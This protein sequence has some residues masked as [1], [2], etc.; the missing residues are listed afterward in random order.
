ML[1]IIKAGNRIFFEIEI[2]GDKSWIIA[3]EYRGREIYFHGIIDG[4]AV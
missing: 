2:K 3:N 1:H 4:N